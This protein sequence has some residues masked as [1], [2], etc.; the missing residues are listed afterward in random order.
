MC[1]S[2]IIIGKHESGRDI[3]VSC[4]KCIEC[5]QT[6]ANEWALR[7][8]YELKDHKD[9][10]FLTLTY[11]NNPVV[12]IKP[13]AQ[14]FIK[15]LRKKIQ[16]KKIKYFL[17]GEYGDQNLRPHFHIIIFGHDFEDKVLR[18]TSGRDNPY[19]MS[20]TLTKLWGHGRAIIQDVNAQVIRYTALY[21]SKNKKDG[22]LPPHLW[23]YPEF[24]TMSQSM[25]VKQMLDKIDTLLL[26]DEVYLDGFSHVIPQIVLNKWENGSQ[27]YLERNEREWINAEMKS[28]RFN[29]VTDKE[30]ALRKHH[31][32]KKRKLERLR[33]L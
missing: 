14:K 33:D 19:F 30:L 31:A 17:C 6:R 22:T 5:R 12:L 15:R 27:D 23:N 10:C 1:Y 13:D 25:G 20:P 7:C 11:E 21:N 4:R 9:S 8:S 28:K 24:N 29:Y 2:P 32:E 26:T 18:G 3:K 16:P